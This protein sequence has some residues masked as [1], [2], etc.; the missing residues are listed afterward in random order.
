MAAQR[1]FVVANWR[2]TLAPRAR[3]FS[4]HE[5]AKRTD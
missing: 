4:G 3:S 1:E 2:V 5:L